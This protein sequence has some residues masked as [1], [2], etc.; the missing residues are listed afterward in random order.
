M[1]LEKTKK[2]YADMLRRKQDEIKK[3][4]EENLK[5]ME[6]TQV[7][8]KEE[9]LCNKTWSIFYNSSKKNNFKINKVYISNTF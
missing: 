5:L 6:I 7:I 2:Q 4:I 1:E 3:K 8:K 9:I